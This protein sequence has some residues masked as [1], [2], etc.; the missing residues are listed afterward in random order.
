MRIWIGRSHALLYIILEGVMVTGRASGSV[1]VILH[2][3]ALER[4]IWLQGAHLDRYEIHL[5]VKYLDPYE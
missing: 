4:T 2:I 1:G 3:S 5:R